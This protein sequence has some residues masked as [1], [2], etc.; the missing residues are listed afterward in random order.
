[1]HGAKIAAWVFPKAS[2]AVTVN[3]FA[4]PALAGVGKPA[5]TK[6][7][8]AAGATVM[9]VWAP[10]IDDAI[11]SAAVRDWEPTDFSVVVKVWTPL[12]AAK[13]M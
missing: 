2:R 5:T 11:V 9:L 7:A 13:N 4:T 6:V 10:V 1:M 12:S 8:A 3:E